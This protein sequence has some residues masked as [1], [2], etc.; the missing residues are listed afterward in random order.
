MRRARHGGGE[1]N[2]T[3]LLDVL[4]SILFIVLLAGAQNERANADAAKEEADGLREEIA[5][6]QEELETLRAQLESAEIIREGARVVTVSNFMSGGV[7]RLRVAV[8][9][10]TREPEVIL[11]GTSRLENV[12]A[13]LGSLAEDVINDSGGFPVYIFFH[14]DKDAIYRRE[15]EAVVRTLEELQREHKEVF[16]RIAEKNEEEHT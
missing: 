4:F 9:G 10:D 15:Y 11:L 16:L 2:L 14:C 12:S 6:L 3:P 13:R 5:D 7:H 8:D 1:I